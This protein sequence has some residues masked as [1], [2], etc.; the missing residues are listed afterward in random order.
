M[1]D[2]IFDL[3]LPLLQNIFGESEVNRRISRLQEIYYNTESSWQDNIKRLASKNIENILI[4]ESAP[5]S[6]IGRPRYFY[7]RIESS[8]H[9]RIWATF[10]PNIEI[11]HDQE[12]AFR[13]LADK[14]FL[15]VD[16]I[17]F[18]MNYKGKR[19]HSD[20][21]NLVANSLGWWK[22]KIKS[23]KINYSQKVNV[24]FAFK[25]NGLAVIKATNGSIGFKNDTLVKFS[26][27]NI[28]AD[29]S[30]YTNSAMLR[31]IFKLETS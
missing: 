7:N 30:G 2:S 4:A 26:Q 17:P 3:N 28:A 29:G 10:F 15:L 16:S 12:K 5:W 20:Y 13:M 24:A 31:A 19:N 14:N 11:P 25:V 9:K 21:F 27:D 8:Y 1:N 22:A 6:E 18:S 23:D